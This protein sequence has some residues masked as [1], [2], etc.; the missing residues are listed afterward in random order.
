[1]STTNTTRFAYILRQNGWDSYQK[2]AIRWEDAAKRAAE[3]END[4]KLAKVTV[5]QTTYK[6]WMGQKG[7]IQTVPRPQAYIVMQ[8]MFKMSPERL[9]ETVDADLL[10]LADD[11]SQEMDHGGL[12]E[13]DSPVTILSRVQRATSSNVDTPVISMVTQAI[14]SI[15][16]RYED[17]G[18]QHLAG[19]TRVI[20]DMLEG[21]LSGHQPPRVRAELFRLS[22]QA[23]GLLGYMAVNAGASF[24]VVDA[25]CTEA[26]VLAREVGEVSMEMWA[27]GTRS[28][29]LYYQ[30]R[31]ADAD[32]AASAGIALDPCNAQAIRLFVNG[33]SRALARLGDRRGAEAAIGQ[34]IDLSE[35]QADLPDGLTPCI[36][37]G[38]YSMA[39]TLANAITAR[40][41]LGDTDEVLTHAS[42]LEDLVEHST[43]KWSRAL[44]GLDVASALLK[45]KSPEVE[46]AMAQGRR[47]LRAG[48]SR[49][50]KSVWKR[51]NELLQSAER[52]RD[53][54]AVGDFAD[55]LRT[56]GS[57]PR[58][59]M[60]TVGSPSPSARR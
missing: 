42:R 44:V 10:A 15:V 54:P 25:Y 56:W 48:T 39:R 26:E 30:Q 8:H 22:S 2:F 23:S 55:E 43:S 32:D 20:R 52:W 1:M 16:D 58:T 3:K 45:Q 33:R 6:R 37:F 14:G 11:S 51:A 18:P 40:L 34:A 49:P 60:V 21:V 31:Y 13:F 57:W 41:S 59:G 36:S 5:A 9:L 12:T 7:G 47:A 17:L 38:R 27:S 29:G 24:E 19:E 46:H 50:I 35:R 28:L 4:P 53:E